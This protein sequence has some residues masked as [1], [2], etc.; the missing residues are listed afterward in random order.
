MTDRIVQAITQAIVEHRL[1]PG[2][3][4]V[5]QTIGHRFGVSRTLVR[6]ALF[7]LQ[8]ARLVTLEPARGAFVAQPSVQEAQE[9]F[10]VRRMLESELMRQLVAH[11]TDADIAQLKAHL[12]DEQQA[13]A[14]LD[15]ARR[16]ALLFD[17][18][19]VL[20]K[21]SGNQV[22]VDLMTDLVSRC[23]LITLMDPSA[24]HTAASHQAHTHIVQAIEARDADQAVA[25][26]A[27]HLHAVE[28]PLTASPDPIAPCHTAT[29]RTTRAT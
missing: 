9:V 18:H 11:A 17:F 2:T 19:V 7:R 26:M 5:E 13:I 15:V 20:A 14:R 22:L 6:Q 1:L 16:T 23:A 24:A 12:A 27:S 3:K 29:T 8:Q 4:L 28:Q 25:L 10:A 21:M